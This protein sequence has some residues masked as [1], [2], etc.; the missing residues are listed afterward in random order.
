MYGWRKFLEKLSTNNGMYSTCDVNVGTCVRNN[1]FKI[2]GSYNYQL[3]H[4]GAYSN[5]D[6][7]QV[8]GFDI[9]IKF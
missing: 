7:P 2:V 9:T 1:G 8:Q 5:Y 4:I 3:N 6:G